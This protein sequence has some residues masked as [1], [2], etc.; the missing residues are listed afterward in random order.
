MVLRLG[1]RNNV[2]LELCAVM[3]SAKL[4]HSSEGSGVDGRKQVVRS[5]E[6]KWS[7]N[8]CKTIR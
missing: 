2:V 4:A 8:D 5:V 3:S 1:E 6:E 7:A